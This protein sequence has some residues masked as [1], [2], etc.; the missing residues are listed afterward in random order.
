MH[1]ATQR[2]P[3]LVLV[4]GCLAALAIIHVVLA[5]T[6]MLG[7]GPTYDEPLHM[8]AG[9]SYWRYDD[10]RLQPE[11]GNLPQRWCAIPLVAKHARL[12]AVDSSDWQ[13]SNLIGLGRQFLYECDN[14][15]ATMLA[16]ARAMA[17]VW[18][19]GIC[20]LTALWSWAVWRSAATALVAAALAAFWPA[21]L[22]HG[23]LA[24]SDACGAFFFTAAAW[25]LWEL[26]Q[27]ATPVTLAAASLA[28]GGAA[29]AKHSCLMLAPL[30]VVYLGVLAAAR[31]PLEGTWGGDR[32]V[33]VTSRTGRTVSAVA[34]L[35]VTLVF[36]VAVIW[37]SCGFR[38][39]PAG[40]GCGP[41]QYR[42]Y[43]TLDICNANAGSMGVLGGWLAAWR[44]LPEA[45]IYGLS[46]VAATIRGRHAFA[47]GHYSTAG[48]W[49]YFPLCLAIKNTLPAL[50]VCG[51]GV[52]ATCGLGFGIIRSRVG[53]PT[54]SRAWWAP[55]LV[56]AVLWPTFLLSRLNIGE[57]HLLPAYPPL[58]VLAGGAWLAAGRRG[59]AAIVLLLA[60][61]AADVAG[62]FPAF[63]PYFNQV[64]PGGAGYRWLAD[65]N[66][67]WGQNLPR[68]AAWVQR[69]RRTGEPLFVDYFGAGVVDRELP[70]AR[71][72]GA[73]D[74][75]GGPQRLEPGLYCIG[76]TAAASLYSEP[77]G[78]WCERF[79]VGYR[80][81]REAILDAAGE[82]RE[83]DLR[84]FRIELGA[85]NAFQAARLRAFLRQ[86]RPDAEVAG[87]VLIHRLSAADLTAALEGKPAELEPTAWLQRENG[88]EIDSCLEEAAAL[89]AAGEL[90]GAA[91]ALGHAIALDG[92]DPRSRWELGLV[93][94]RRGD[95]AAAA[96]SFTI[97]HLLE[98]GDPRPIC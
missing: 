82:P 43:E 3:Q 74:A 7:T 58:I 86:R 24:T 57:R 46:Y 18:S 26:L 39:D 14:D 16:A 17:V 22:A 38:Y 71:I 60:L 92:Y 47:L 73:T 98:S 85:F 52:I 35:L 97:V 81:A 4:A 91:A 78:P 64:V 36:A 59:R 27:R 76:V 49:W 29:V 34:L 54:V 12:P 84:G 10:Y 6:A 75:D 93:Q 37:A 41:V 32:R 65:S 95:L 23:P 70:D 77:Y 51:W 67:D 80:N 1:D 13:K 25:A 55:A 33:A 96:S 66:S 2:V 15:P 56:L 89:S 63:L 69:H 87:T 45:W 94:E 21:F 8:V 61:H 50:V 31:S 68:L 48:W 90:A 9:A 83:A 20:L 5:F 53:Q 44:V 28:V 62:H 40:P 88:R 11:N 79:E 42:R 30:A 19:F 72:L